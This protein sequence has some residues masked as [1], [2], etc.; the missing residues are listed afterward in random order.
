MLTYSE[1]SYPI[2]KIEYFDEDNLA[3]LQRGEGLPKNVKYQLSNYSKH[4]LSG[5]KI[6]TSYKLADNCSEYQIGRIYPIDQL[7][8]SG[9]RFDV[10]NPL[11]QKYY[12]DIDMENAHYRIA[13]KYCIDN[14]LPHDNIKKYVENRDTMLKSV[15]SS[16]KKAKTEFLKILY[17]GDVKLY[18]CFYDEVDGEINTEAFTT[19]KSLQSEVSILMEIIWSKNSHLHNLKV[20]SDKKP[21]NKLPTQKAKATMMSLIFQTEERKLL[22]F[23]D[24]F[25]K[26]KN[27]SMEVF[28]HDGGYIRKQEGESCFP[29]ELLAQCS[30]AIKDVMKYEIPLAQ[31]PIVYD[32]IN[33]IAK[34][35]YY[36]N[37]KIEIESRYAQ[38]GGDFIE[39]VE[40]EEPRPVSYK[41]CKAMFKMY[42]YSELNL[43]TNKM[44]KKYFFD[45]WTDD[46]NHRFYSKMDFIPN[47]DQCPKDVFNLFTGF[48]AEKLIGNYQY[49]EELIKPI[50]THLDLLTEGRSDWLLQWLACKIQQPYR[51]TMVIPLFRDVENFLELCG[52]TGKTTFLD[53]FGSE[54]LGEKY[55]LSIHNNEDFYNSFNGQ[56]E[57]KL[58][59]NIEEA[60]GATHHKNDNILK[61]RTT[62]TKLNINKKNINSY[63]VNDYADVATSTNT[64]NPFKVNLSNRRIAPFDVS[65]IHRNDPEYFKILLALYKN[66]QAIY[67]FYVYLRDSVE[68]PDKFEIPKT[69]ALVDMTIMNS[70]VQYKWIAHL[71]KTHS[72]NTMY[73]SDA[74]DNFSEFCKTT[75]ESRGSMSLTAFGLLLTNTPYIEK[76]RDKKGQKLIFKTDEIV[77]Q[78]RTMALLESDFQ[79]NQECLIDDD[80]D[81]LL[82]EASTAT[83]IDGILQAD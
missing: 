51:K 48:K 42:N 57:G 4:R 79:Y 81:D 20:G 49:D 47:R 33:F 50:I 25:M 75:R 3:F 11:A 45:T 68:V 44:E 74:Y 30:S 76:Q 29:E 28:I 56:F 17:G 19:L 83:Y 15:S 7:S 9:M 73:V 36:A 13:L 62:A 23:I 82:S 80:E 71:C 38:V 8:M 72:L 1:P 26:S 77:P 65:N 40:D 39:I 46:I 2:S 10:R 61:A 31:K 58:L 70:P 27:R 66:K 35:D 22:M 60:E 5:G 12:W 43:Q 54:I 63:K 14:E 6:S 69:K 34:N 55:Y 41:D 53:W 64:K 32:Q 59:I 67:S 16:R 24:S 37:K 78:L 52:G 18:N 21:I